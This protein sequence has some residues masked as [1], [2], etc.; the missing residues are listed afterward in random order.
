MYNY[1]IIHIA[2]LSQRYMGILGGEGFSLPVIT[3]T[4]VV[5]VKIT[6]TDNAINLGIKQSQAECAPI[7][8][9]LWNLGLINLDQ[10]Q[11]LLN[12]QIKNS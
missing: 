12:W 8:V 9:V 10:Y 6:V 5:N 3:Q 4:E 11:E 1:T 7:S 2:L